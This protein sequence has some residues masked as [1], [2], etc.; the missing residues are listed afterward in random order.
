MNELL[1]PVLLMAGTSRVVVTWPTVGSLRAL[2]EPDHKQQNHRADQRCGDRT[3]PA[4][5]K[6]DV[7]NTRKPA[8]DESA[9]DADHDVYK[10]AKAAATHQYTRQP[11]SDSANHNP[12]DQS[13]CHGF[14]PSLKTFFVGSRYWTDCGKASLLSWPDIT[15]H[16]KRAPAAQPA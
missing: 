5:P 16:Q 2:D 10:Q 11:A 14:I 13:M 8:T 4:C 1:T 6:R 7:Q 3:D 15:G 9:D 12:S